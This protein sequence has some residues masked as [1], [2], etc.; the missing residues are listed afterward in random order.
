MGMQDEP[1]YVNEGIMAHVPTHW[2]PAFTDV[3]FD[4]TAVKG[5]DWR[6]QPNRLHPQQHIGAH[7]AGEWSETCRQCQLEKDALLERD[8]D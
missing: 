5:Y 4:P 3:G 6:T 8:E 7:F 1:I 2:P